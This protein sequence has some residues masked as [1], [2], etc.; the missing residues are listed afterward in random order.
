MSEYR[1]GI[2]GAGQIAHEFAKGLRAVPGAVLHSVCSRTSDKVTGFGSLYGVEHTFT[3]MN[4]FLAD[5]QLDIVYVA[6]PNR[7]HAEQAERCIRAGKHVLV[8][9]PFALNAEQAGM[10][11]D[12]ARTHKRLCMEGMWSRFVP[13][14]QKVLEEV[15]G[16]AVGEIRYL[17]A[18][19]GN[20]RIFNPYTKLF[21]PASGGGAL[22]DLGVYPLSLA[23]MFLG[24]PERVEA[25]GRK[26]ASGVDGAVNMTLHYANGAYA[27]LHCSVDCE[28]PNRVW[29]GGDRGH[30]DISPP[31]YLPTRYR[32]VRTAPLD[33]YTSSHGF[34]KKEKLRW[35]PL[36]CAL[37]DGVRQ[38]LEPFR[39]LK[40]LTRAPYFA[41][42]Y[43]YQASAF[44]KALD[45]G[46]SECEIMP[47]GDTLKLYELTDTIRRQMGIEFPGVDQE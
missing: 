41:N 43:Q 29:I 34:G 19:F 13:A 42:G 2:L 3:D 47:L 33:I 1:W 27:S 17:S 12:A 9:K 46:K 25:S 38:L 28:L 6:T 14:Y 44:M 45:E 15:R 40:T 39:E 21:D 5:S 30:V 16:G 23:L 10:V 31:L 26:T 35:Q 37:M 20:T 8:E 36:A 7:L 24:V 22:L 18:S 11:V 4:A 32:L